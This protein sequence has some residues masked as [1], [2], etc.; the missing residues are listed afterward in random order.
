MIKRDLLKWLHVFKSIL[1]AFRCDN[2][3]RE[4]GWSNDG[5]WPIS[6]TIHETKVDF[7]LIL[8]LKLKS[9]ENSQKIHFKII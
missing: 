9:L 4:S 8:D 6:S 3:S 2:N 5:V 7:S 1:I